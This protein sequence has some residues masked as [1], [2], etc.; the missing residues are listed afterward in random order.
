MWC[1][2]CGSNKHN[3]ALCP[4][5]WGGSSARANLWCSY[6]GKRDHDI[7]ACP[8]TWD[9]S[10]ARA[11]DEDSVSDHFVKDRQR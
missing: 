7:N 10:A 4:K 8:K 11:W 5:T 2:Y 9:G 1:S 6:C 3:Y